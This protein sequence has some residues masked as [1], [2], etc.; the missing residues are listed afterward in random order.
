MKSNQSL[1]D[2][3]FNNWQIC[4]YIAYLETEQEDRI[5]WIISYLKI[6]YLIRTVRV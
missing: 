3:F 6:D 5:K 4:L 1:Q 2:T